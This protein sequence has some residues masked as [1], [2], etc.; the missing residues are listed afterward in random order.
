MHAFRLLPSSQSGLS[1]K[2]TSKMVS[3]RDLFLAYGEQA[4]NL[5]A[6]LFLQT[7]TLPV[8]PAVLMTGALVPI[9]HG[10]FASL[11]TPQSTLKALRKKREE[12]GDDD[13]D[14]DDEEEAALPETLTSEDAYWLPV[15]GS[16]VLFSMFLVFKYLDKK[17]VDRVLG[18]YFALVG[19]LAVSKVRPYSITFSF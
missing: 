2:I 13:D 8:L 6:L 19:S 3:D 1:V 12:G 14:D 15:I 18:S 4:V 11:R 9:Y 7:L 17:W 5:V 16:V 10:A